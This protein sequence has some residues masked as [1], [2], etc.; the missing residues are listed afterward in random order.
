M[1][2]AQ[3]SLPG[4]VFPGKVNP[5]FTRAVHNNTWKIIRNIFNRISLKK[6]QEQSIPPPPTTQKKP[7]KPRHCIYH[8]KQC[9]NIYKRLLCAPC[10]S[11]SHLSS[12]F[13]RKVTIPWGSSSVPTFHS[14]LHQVSLR[15][16]FSLLSF[17]SSLSF[18]C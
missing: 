15:L 7:T 14:C 4:L 13:N 8:C 9:R 5:H 10:M 16:R 11:Y 2:S 12:S 1:N 18:F 17:S 6:T 3:V